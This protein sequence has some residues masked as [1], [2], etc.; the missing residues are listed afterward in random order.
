MKIGFISELTANLTLSPN[1]QPIW[2]F[3]RIYSR[4]GSFAEFT[5]NFTLSP[6]V[7]LSVYLLHILKPE[8]PTLSN[9]AQN[10]QLCGLQLH[11][12][13]TSCSLLLHRLEIC[14][15]IPVS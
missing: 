7:L 13:G 15:L 4:F 14:L 9:D 3:L 6:N 10:P 11:L 5:E 8:Y 1:G 12:G 2:L